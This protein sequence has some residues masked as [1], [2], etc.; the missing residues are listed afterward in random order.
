M[1][2][3]DGHF[4]WHRGYFP[5]MR[6][7]GDLKIWRRQHIID[8][9]SLNADAVYR[10]FSMGVLNRWKAIFRT[11]NVKIDGAVPVYPF[12]LYCRTHWLYCVEIRNVENWQK[13]LTN[14]FMFDLV[15]KS[16][17]CY[18]KI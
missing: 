1:L 2:F 17:L 5:M 11:V 4:V 8:F 15:D 10:N 6:V 13:D 3:N 18:G 12:G 7:I 16:E 14:L 9:T